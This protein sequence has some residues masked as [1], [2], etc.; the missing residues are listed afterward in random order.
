ME[1]VSYRHTD[2]ESY[3]ADQVSGITARELSSCCGISFA[4]LVLEVSV[5]DQNKNTQGQQKGQGQQQGSRDDQN[6]NTESHPTRDQAEGS[7]DKSRGNMGS[8]ERGTGNQG[9]KNRSGIS[10][11][12]MSQDEEQLD[13]PPRGSSDDDSMDQSER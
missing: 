4:T 1:T 6:R 7:R 10:N 9:E 12:G 8:Q 5:M 2:P 13:L 11:R 3:F